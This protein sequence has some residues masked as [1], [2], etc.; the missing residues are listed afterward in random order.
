ML[1]QTYTFGATSSDNF[2]ACVDG[3][4]PIPDI[5]V[6][7]I[8]ATTPAQ[9][10]TTVDKI[11]GYYSNKTYGW[12]NTALLIAGEEEEFHLQTDSIVHSMIPPNFF[13]KRLYT[14]IQNQQVDTKY[15]GTT[16]DLLS[17]FNQGLVLVNFMGHGGGAIW[18]D[19][20]ILT[21]DEVAGMSN[22]GKYPFV[23]S[24]TCFAG[25]FDGQEGP[26]LSSTLLFAQNKGAVGVLASAGLGWE[27][28]DF[29]MDG[30]LLP[31]IFDSTNTNS[32]IGYDILPAKAQ[33]YASYYYWPQSVTMLNQYN[34]IG[35]PALVIQ[36]PADNSMVQ[37][38]SYTA[39]SGQNV[40]GNISNGPSKASG[41][42]Q[43]TNNDGDV[44]G[45]SNVSLDNSGS[46]T[47]S[48]PF[49]GGFSGEGH[50]KAYTYNNSIQS[51]SRIDFS[52]E[53][54]FAQIS[55]FGITMSGNN[56]QI[57]VAAYASTASN[58]TAFNFA[59]QIYESINSTGDKLVAT[60]SIPLTYTQN[61]YFGV[62]YISADT[63]KPGEIINGSLQAK[64]SDGSTV[65]G[66][67]VSYTVPGA[68][69]VSAFSSQGYVNINSSIKV[70]ADSVVKLEA[71]VY[72]LNRV[73]VQNLRVDFY[74]GI[75]ATGVRLGSARVSFDT[76]SQTLAS[77]PTSISEG[78]H[79]VYI[80]VVFDSLT[81]GYDLHPENNFAYNSIQVNFVVANSAGTVAIDSS[82]SLSG[83]PSGGIFTVGKTSPSLY[84]Q[85]FII[86]AKNKNAAAQFYQFAPVSGSQAG[87]YSLSI[88]IYSPDSTTNANLSG[89]HLYLYDPRT[90][91]LDLAGGNYINGKVIGTVDELGIFTA[92]YSADH[93]PPQ[94]TI[95]VGDQFFSNGDY[96]PPNPRFSFLLH[97][98]DG[99][100]LEKKNLNVQLDGAP[101]DTSTIVLPDTITDPT[102][103]TASV[104]LQTK[105]NG[106][107]TLQVT[108]EDANGNVS[109][110]VS[111]DFTVA[112]D[113]SLKDY[114][115]FPDP[116]VNQTFIAF[117]VTSAYSID[118]VEIK[119]YSVSGRLVKTIRYPSNNPQETVGLLQGGTGSPTAVGYHEAWWDGTDNYDNQVANGVYFYKISVSSGGKTLQDI[120]KMARLR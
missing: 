14:S 100:N 43:I 88:S 50:V 104:Q 103:V 21:N 111:V 70:V 92:A 98:E 72:N 116:F 113:F 38:N 80:Y 27:Y 12:Q 84:P 4:D 91:T 31:L 5:A 101:V 10:E 13:I 119:I 30:E 36:L 46:G 52:T 117:E 83:A 68:A 118:G 3:P 69:D 114:G 54:S 86:T 35:D 58:I 61:E 94:V 64:L 28:N 56:F 109:Q 37:L 41:V 6:G 55:G 63:L 78:N 7:R 11:L 115:A 42:V 23:T 25:A 110:P 57:S 34:L 102:S 81:N 32:S 8:P 105:T 90:R 85:P 82:A 108:A 39:T 29:Y 99:V 93:T 26:P 22:N 2:Y 77:I 17:Y 48:V 60:F 51:S 62:G 73:P 112:S 95:S 75:R 67:Q 87:S 66:Q 45:Q 65:S 18:A 24:M 106:S 16:P 1:M 53:S 59:G 74:D 79:T 47:F 107:H 97:D 19:N 120:G 71:L 15:Y 76:T 44:M 89:L 33:Y 20:G 96:V 49:S 40:S 9:L